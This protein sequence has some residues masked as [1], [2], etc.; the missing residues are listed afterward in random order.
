M[1]QVV[2]PWIFLSVLDGNQKQWQHPVMFGGLWDITYQQLQ[3]RN[4]IP[5]TGIL[6]HYDVYLVRERNSVNIVLIH[7]ILKNIF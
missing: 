7:R 5:S 2:V 6:L 1:I 4:L 3:K